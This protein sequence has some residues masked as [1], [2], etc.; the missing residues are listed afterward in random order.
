MFIEEDLRNTI[1]ELKYM[2]D[3]RDREIETLKNLLA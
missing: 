1:S 3:S 2:V